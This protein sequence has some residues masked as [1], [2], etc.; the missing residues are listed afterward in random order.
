[1]AKLKIQGD[2]LNTLPEAKELQ[3]AKN[4][5]FGNKYKII[6]VPAYTKMKSFSGKYQY[7]V[8]KFN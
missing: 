1:M 3:R 8:Y 2:V 6:R 5:R 4:M 7:V